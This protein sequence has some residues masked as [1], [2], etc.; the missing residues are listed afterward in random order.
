MIFFTFVIIIRSLICLFFCLSDT[1][2]DLLSLQIA[3]F[4]CS[5]F[6]LR[7]LKILQ[8]ISFSLLFTSDCPLTVKCCIIDVR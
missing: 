2:G 4:F 1:I 3:C 5:N 7:F 6:T 8:S